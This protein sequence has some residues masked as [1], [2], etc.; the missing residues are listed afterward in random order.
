MGEW[1]SA[2]PV[3]T[4]PVQ[5]GLVIQ[6]RVHPTFNP[7]NLFNDVAILRLATP[8]ILGP[9]PNPAINTACLPTATTVADRMRFFLLVYMILYFFYSYI[10]RCIVS[11][12]GQNAFNGA[13]QLIIREVDVPVIPNADCQNSLRTTKLG[14]TFVLDNNS[15]MCAGGEAGRDACIVSSFIQNFYFFYKGII[16]DLCPVTSILLS[17]T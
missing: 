10:F 9:V 11:G 2:R 15:F 13:F 6:I 8:I 14:Q 7:R 17:L 5:E 4:Y 12:W 16:C 3:E 1:D